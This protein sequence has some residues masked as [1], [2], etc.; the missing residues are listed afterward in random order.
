VRA[1][2]EDVWGQTGARFALLAEN[3]TTTS[4]GADPD[5]ADHGADR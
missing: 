1:Y 2:L 3:T 4:I 5:H